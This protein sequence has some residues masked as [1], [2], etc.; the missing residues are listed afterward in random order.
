MNT[1][2][3]IVISELKP[4]EIDEASSLLANS[5]ATNPNHLAIFKSTKPSVIKKQKKMFGMVLSNRHNLT[6]LAKMNEKIVGTMTYTTSG[7]C[8]LSLGKIII[9]IPRLIS[10]FGIHLLS[11]LQWRMN[12]AKHDYRHKH[13]HFGPVAVDSS[14]QGKG[15]GKL[16]LN[17][18]CTYLDTTAQAGYLE[19]DKEQNVKLYEKFGFRIIA[20]DHL[21]GV[22]NWFMLRQNL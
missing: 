19:T 22:K 16:L 21:F 8:Q 20:T 6:Y 10:I 7:H 2:A 12:W 18:Y 9:S 15:I 11:V 14:C 17:H 13:N 4:E 3:D 5:M 1:I